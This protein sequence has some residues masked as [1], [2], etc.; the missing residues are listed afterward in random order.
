MGSDNKS[1]R[2]GRALGAWEREGQG[3]GRAHGMGGE[4]K[5]SA[6]SQ[7]RGHSGPALWP[8]GGYFRGNPRGGSQQWSSAVQA[9]PSRALPLTSWH[10]GSLVIAA[11]PHVSGGVT[12]LVL[13]LLWAWS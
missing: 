10:Q 7:E 3:D 12:C 9:C 8:K 2:P 4:G 11:E 5:A 13:L 6:R 1:Q